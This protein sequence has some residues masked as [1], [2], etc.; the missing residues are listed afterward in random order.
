MHIFKYVQS[1]IILHQHLS[2]TL[3]IIIGALYNNNT[4][5]IQITDHFR[6][7]LKS[8]FILCTTSLIQQGVNQLHTSTKHMPNF[9]EF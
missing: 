6:L 7:S 9:T 1:Y 5:S 2:V 8:S 3:V 4:I